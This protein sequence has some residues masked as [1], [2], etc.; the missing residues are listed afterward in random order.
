MTEKLLAVA[1]PGAAYLL[2]LAAVV[3][4]TDTLSVGPPGDLPCVAGLAI[5]RDETLPVYSLDVVLGEAMHGARSW[6]DRD[7]GGFVIARIGERHC[8]LGVSRII[9]LVREAE[10]PMLDLPALLAPILPE[11]EPAAPAALPETAPSSRYLVAGIGGRRCA[12]AVNVVER[13]LDSCRVVR[14]PCARGTALVGVGT[15]EGRVLP[16]I[17]LRLLLGC[18]ATAPVT[19]YVVVATADIGR[20]ILAVDQVLG[21]HD[22]ADDTLDLP[23]E[24]A[25][26]SILA[27]TPDGGTWVLSP[28]LITPTLGELA[29]EA[30]A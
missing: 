18:K 1:T 26:H 23:R 29:V 15:I 17:D 12:L 8:A 10:Q 22:I 2:P 19:G 24:G 28:S 13:V 30:R 20:L 16:V 5:H 4:L 9:G 27:E 3:E 7:W 21:L 6:E 25:P 11:A 14:A